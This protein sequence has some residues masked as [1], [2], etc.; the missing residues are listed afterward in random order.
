MNEAKE[1]D[2]G[3]VGFESFQAPSF[4]LQEFRSGD[5]YIPIHTYLSIYRSIYLSIYL[6]LS[7][8]HRHIYVYIHM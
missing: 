4:Q 2:V 3:V 7:S 8:I 1:T 6:S 5:I